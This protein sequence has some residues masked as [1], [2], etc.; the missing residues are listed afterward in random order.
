MPSE[1]LPPLSIVHV[2]APGPVGG[3][4]RVV[5][6][7]ATGHARQGHDV[8][9]ISLLV[10]GQAAGHPFAEPLR[11]AGVRVH[12]LEFPAKALLRER[13]AVRDLLSR[14]R[15][16][17]VHTHWYR[18]DVL[19]ATTARG[20]GIPTVTTEHGS[21]KLGGRTVVYEWIQRAFFRRFQ[22]VV[23]VSTPIA[24]RLV[25]EG[26]PK[27][28]VHLIPNGWGGG[29]DFEDRATARRLL[30]L[31]NDCPVVGYVGRLIPAKGPDVFLDAVLRLDDLDLRAVVI[32]DGPE[33]ARLEATIRDADGEDTVR[34]A[35]HVDDAAPL[36]KAFD[37]FVLSSRT[38]GTPITLFEAMA[39]GVPIVATAVGG[40][41]QVVSSREALLV[42]PGDPEALA[43]GIRC[44]LTAPTDSAE[45][46]ERASKRLEADFGADQWLQR[47]ETLYRAVAGL[48]T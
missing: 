3:L 7:L 2:V 20:L 26:V 16:D 29:V 35:G 11:P 38:E 9:V 25:L 27:S 4:E 15:P 22:A 43:H 47:H 30:G 32:G 21:S 5:Q 14:I 39:A 1:T 10:P 40:V 48:T 23:A 13:R 24:E 28:K 34:M 12:E 31:P 6:A 37:L 41:P 8:S 36:F 18:P 44:A 46:A 33:R 19:H 17:V 42:P 45:R